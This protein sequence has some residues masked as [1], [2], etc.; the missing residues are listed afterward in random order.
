MGIVC[1]RYAVI[2]GRT[3][4]GGLCSQHGLFIL[5]W[6]SPL[7]PPGFQGRTG[8]APRMVSDILYTV[9][10]ETQVRKPAPTPRLMR[11]AAYPGG[12]SG[13]DAL[14]GHPFGI[15]G[16]PTAPRVCGFMG[17]CAAS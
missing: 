4:S 1:E 6:P 14:S 5:G 7:S 13:S 15:D 2:S 12:R 11:Q 16:S 9:R 17:D 3:R 10:R 8:S